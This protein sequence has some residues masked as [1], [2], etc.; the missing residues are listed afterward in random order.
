MGD[1]CDVNAPP[2]RTPVPWS[3]RW[4]Y[5][6]LGTG[7]GGGSQ[8]CSRKGKASEAAPEAVE[9]AVGGGCQSGWG[10]VIVGYKCH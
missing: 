7:R 6:G 3:C 10:A 9:S 5:E 2:P 4:C 8:G 1:R